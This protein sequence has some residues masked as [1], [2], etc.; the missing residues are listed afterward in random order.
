[1]SKNINDRWSMRQ[2]SRE[3]ISFVNN[4]FAKCFP[5]AA[6]AFIHDVC[7]QVEF[8]FNTAIN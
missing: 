1:M 5:Y 3:R 4:L 2:T 7:G 6:E 8:C